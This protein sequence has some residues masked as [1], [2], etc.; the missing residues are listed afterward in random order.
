MSFHE[1]VQGPFRRLLWPLGVG[2][3]DGEGRH[4]A[5]PYVVRMRQEDVIGFEVTMTKTPRHQERG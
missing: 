1:G 2:N 5:C 4:E 3:A